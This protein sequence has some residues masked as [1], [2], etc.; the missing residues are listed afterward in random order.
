LSSCINNET[1]NT[2]DE[3]VEEFQGGIYRMKSERREHIPSLGME[4]GIWGRME[5]ERSANM[6]REL[7]QT[8]LRSEELSY[9]FRENLHSVHLESKSLFPTLASL[10][11][12]T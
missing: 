7:F 2:K 6:S 11:T 3:E 12:H 8:T 9:R 10:E 4:S 5:T 1:R